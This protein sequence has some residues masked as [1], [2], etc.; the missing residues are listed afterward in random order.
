MQMSASWPARSLLQC[1]GQISGA[2]PGLSP[3]SPSPSSSSLILTQ[4][5]FTQSPKSLFCLY[6]HCH[7]PAQD[8]SCWTFPVWPVRACSISTS[9]SVTLL[10]SIQHP[11]LVLLPFSFIIHFPSSTGLLCPSLTCY[12]GS[13]FSL[14]LTLHDFNGHL[15]C[16]LPD[17]Y[18]SVLHLP[19]ALY[20]LYSTAFSTHLYV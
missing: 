17:T 18:L 4:C 8:C 10:H 11:S 5:P 13:G 14:A 16:C 2:R 20:S 15:Y 3:R 9:A 6:H 19:R 1:C 7:F 12:C